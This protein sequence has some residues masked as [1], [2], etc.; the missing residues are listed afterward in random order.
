MRDTPFANQCTVGQIRSGPVG[1][2]SSLACFDTIRVL[3]SS[4][5]PKAGLDRCLY[6]YR[7]AGRNG[8]G[9]LKI[10]SDQSPDYCLDRQQAATATGPDQI[11]T[12][13]AQGRVDYEDNEWRQG[14]GKRR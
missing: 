11:H 10:R 5:L 7:R 12:M 3:N 6:P 1:L 9:R 13:V 2:Q 8:Q 14:S 4:P